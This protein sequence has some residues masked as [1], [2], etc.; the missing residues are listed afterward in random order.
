[1]TLPVVIARSEGDAATQGRDRMAWVPAAGPPR[2]ACRAIRGLG[3][4]DS[5]VHR[6]EARSSRGRFQPVPPPPS[7]D[8]RPRTL[9]IAR[10]LGY[11]VD[12]HAIAAAGGAHGDRGCGGSSPSLS[13]RREVMRAS[14]GQRRQHPVPTVHS[15]SPA[16]RVPATPLIGPF[17]RPRPR[18]PE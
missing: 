1:M 3:S 17:A 16:R 5:G 6:G 18:P 8:S 7:P 15:A 12:H 4:P 14:A 2:A 9:T 11:R 13:G 10:F